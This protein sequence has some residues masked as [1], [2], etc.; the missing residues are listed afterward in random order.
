[1]NTLNLSHQPLRQLAAPLLL[2]N[3]HRPPLSASSSALE[4]L[5]DFS[6]LTPRTIAADVG[7]DEAHLMMRHGGIRLLLVI[8]DRGHCLG[9]L[10]AREVIGDRRITLAMQERDLSRDEVTVGMIMTPWHK[11]S[12]MPLE[13]LASLTIEDLLLSLE[14]MTDQ[15]LL[16]TEHGHQ[17]REW[18]R[19]L[20]SAADIRRAVGSNGGKLSGVPVAQSFADICR[21]VTGHDL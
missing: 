5:T 6:V 12:A 3:P 1:M 2:V 20:V 10:T 14:A 16:V 15:H 7:V 21:V 17:G 18:I 9:V 11:L 8:D 13:Q 4:V 19:G